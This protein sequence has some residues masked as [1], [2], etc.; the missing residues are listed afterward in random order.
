MTGEHREVQARRIVVGLDEEG[1]STI[2]EDG[3]T[4]T[5]LETDAFTLNQIWQATSVPTPV[6][7]DN[8]LGD[9]AVIP[10]PA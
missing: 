7:A 5:R 1:R 2:V 8:T 6:T 4:G 10:V 3:P 9:N